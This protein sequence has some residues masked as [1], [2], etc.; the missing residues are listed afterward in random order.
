MAQGEVKY[1]P[2]SELNALVCKKLSDT[3][4]YTG[5]TF[6]YL[7]V[8]EHALTYAALGNDK[9]LI[10]NRLHWPV[11]V[12][13][14]HASLKRLLKPSPR[15]EIALKPIVILDPVRLTQ[16]ADGEYHSIYI[17]KWLSVI[18]AHVRT[19]VQKKRDKRI[20]ADYVLTDFNRNH[21]AFDA[22]EQDLLIELKDI[23]QKVRSSKVFTAYE[24]QHIASTM[25]IFWEDF[26]FYYRWLKH[27]KVE[28][29]LFICHYH[30][31][32]LLAACK[33][34]AIESVELQHG[35]I[36]RND[37]YY[38]YDKQF[39][40]VVRKA[41][42]PDILMV[43]GDYWRNVV[44]EGVEFLPSQ[45]QVAGDYLY[46]LPKVTTEEVPKENVVLVCAQKMMHSEY[47]AYF[48]LLHQYQLA[49]PEWKVIVKMHPLEPRKDLYQKVK[50]YGFELIDMERNLDDLLR[51]AKIQ[52][53]I[54]S[55]TFFDA[56]GFNVVNFSLQEY[57]NYSDYAADIVKEAVAFPIAI[58]E[59][60]IAKYML[61]KD[62]LIPM[63]RSEIY[64]GFEM[65]KMKA[66][67]HIT[68]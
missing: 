19:I 51:I 57:G 35:L 33:L 55:T 6:S 47:L 52:I 30:N 3:K 17:D 67:L 4:L 65:D 2:F 56:V 9:K 59:N 22:T 14:M 28:K 37:L 46:R 41:M 61:A 23:L 26:R 48:E 45:V 62:Q 7:K 27:G 44:L 8:M 5:S 18:P 10:R 53:S 49:F 12:Q 54:Y 13:N 34:L 63:E 11:I 39:S 21:G 15:L 29:I 1:I 43:Y 58:T 40:S 66:L 38:V 36:A 68:E 20:Y 24:L 31:E 50:T 64:A 42:F 16:G 60:P 25:Y 32:G